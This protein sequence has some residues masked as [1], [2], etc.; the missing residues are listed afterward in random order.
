[1]A[2]RYGGEEF[3][4]ILPHTDTNGAR[5]LLYKLLKTVEQLNLTHAPGATYQAVTVSIGYSTFNPENTSSIEYDPSTIIETADIALYESKQ[6]GR[7]CLHYNPL[8][9]AAPST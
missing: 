8:A 6:N 5:K 7:N 9:L 3:A 2:A 1:M 4:F